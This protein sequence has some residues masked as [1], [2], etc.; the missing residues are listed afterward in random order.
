M[1]RADPRAPGACP[2]PATPRRYSRIIGHPGLAAERKRGEPTRP[3]TANRKLR[4]QRRSTPSRRLAGDEEQP[5]R[6]CPCRN[7][8]QRI[9]SAARQPPPGERAIPGPMG[10]EISISAQFWSAATHPVDE[11]VERKG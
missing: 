1:R 5:R 2:S 4:P 3:T 8:E 9:A 10:S 11:A 6:P 7:T